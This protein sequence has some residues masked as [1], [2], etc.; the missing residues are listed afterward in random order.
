MA[1][2][3]CDT[4]KLKEDGKDIIRLVSDY[5]TQINDFFRELDNLEK[6]KVWTGTNSDIYRK[7]VAPDKGQYVDFGEGLKEIGQE[8]VNF[9]EDLD[10]TVR[11]NESEHD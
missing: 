4:D 2:F 1:D 9:S 7:I 11:Q 5:N 10:V 3:V 8:M 6:N